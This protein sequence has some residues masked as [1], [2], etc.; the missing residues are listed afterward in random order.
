MARTVTKY[1]QAVIE[2]L[3]KYSKIPYAH[4]DLVDETIFDHEAGRYLLIT[5]GWQG[6]KRINAIVLH[7]DVHDEKIWIQCNNTDQDI[8]QELAELGIPSN[9]ILLPTPSN[10]TDQSQLIVSA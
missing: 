7:L 5:L 6:G 10:H 1:Q 9:A 4:D 3:T 8:V 2:L